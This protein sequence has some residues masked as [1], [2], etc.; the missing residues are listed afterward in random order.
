[1]VLI[2]VDYQ[3]IKPFEHH[4]LIPTNEKFKAGK[5][6]FRNHQIIGRQ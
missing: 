3:P 2:N 4:F 5:T 6:H 1:M